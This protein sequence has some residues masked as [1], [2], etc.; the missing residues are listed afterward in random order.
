MKGLQAQFLLGE[1]RF[2]MSNAWLP[3]KLKLK[4]KKEHGDPIP[5][6]ESSKSTKSYDLFITNIPWAIIYKHIKNKEMALMRETG[7]LGVLHGWC[8]QGSSFSS[9]VWSLNRKSWTVKVK[10][11]RVSGGKVGIDKETEWNSHLCS[12]KVEYKM[13][14]LEQ[15]AGSQQDWEKFLHREIIRENY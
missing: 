5:T 8:W 9:K 12:C 10:L 14:G 2:H 4:K 13:E 15:C 3:K 7:E 1:L 11:K 6:T